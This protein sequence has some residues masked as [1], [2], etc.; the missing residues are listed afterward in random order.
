[1]NTIVYFLK[2]VV[3]FR[4]VFLAIDSVFIWLNIKGEMPEEP[5]NKSTHNNFLQAISY[6]WII[7]M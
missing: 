4:M 7:I 5:M 3:V 6:E 2:N 1:M